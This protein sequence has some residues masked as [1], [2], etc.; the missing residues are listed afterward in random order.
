MNKITFYFI[1][2]FGFASCNTNKKEANSSAATSTSQTSPA[3]N[4][5]RIISLQSEPDTLK[6]SLKA[7][8]L[9]RIGKVGVTVNYYSP[10][11]RNR[12]IW[13]GLVPFDNVWVTGA[14]QATSVEVD[15][16]I[17]VGGTRIARGTYALFTIPGKA[18]W[19]I[20]L[21]KN[22]HQH[23]ADDYSQ[24]DDIVRVNVKPGNE[25]INQER[26]RYSIEKENDSIGKIVIHWEKLKVAVPIEAAN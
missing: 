8:A 26:L 9:A 25:R 3:K 14:H 6:G 2:A 4:D 23:L 22:W 18:V 13:G 15:G 24:N 5:T 10:S 12:V 20:I 1:L 17:K 11:V 16:E 19:T 7:K 21:N